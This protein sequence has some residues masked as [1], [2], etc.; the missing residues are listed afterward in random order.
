MVCNAYIIDTCRL[1]ASGKYVPG[2]ITF[3]GKKKCEILQWREH[4]YKT[5]R[6]ADEFVRRHF[7]D[8][9][10]QEAGHEGEIAQIAALAAK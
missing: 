9:G 3:K 6:E 7:E 4:A 5:Q 10:L 1:A 2:A 8:K